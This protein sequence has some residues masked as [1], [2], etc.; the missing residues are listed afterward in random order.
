[1]NGA[2]ITPRFMRHFSF[3]VLGVS[4]VQSG[5][6]TVIEGDSPQPRPYRLG[7]DAHL[8][9][10]IDIGGLVER[11]SRPSWGATGLFFSDSEPLGEGFPDPFQLLCSQPTEPTLQLDRR[12]GLNLLQV[13]GPRP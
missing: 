2:L 11:L 4:V 8:A 1:M 13:K 6:V 9:L 5:A 12:D 10:G 7:S 3:C